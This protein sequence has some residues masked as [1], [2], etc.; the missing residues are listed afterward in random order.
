MTLPLAT[1]RLTATVASPTAV[2]L[3]WTAVSNAT[4]YR[5]YQ[6]IGLRSTLLMKLGA[7][8][9]SWEVTGLVPRSTVSFYLE[10]YNGSVVADSAIAPT[11]SCPSGP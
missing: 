1:P 4:G 3:A 9:T 11:V 8:V 7:R 2:K 6:V 5:A 10:A